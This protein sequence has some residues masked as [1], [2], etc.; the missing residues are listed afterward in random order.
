MVF[1]GQFIDHDLTLDLTSRFD[2]INEPGAITNFR[3]PTLDLD[4]IY[5]DGPEGSPFLYFA[6]PSQDAKSV[7]NGAKL[8]TGADLQGATPE[9]ADD[10][11]RNSNGIAVI[12]D[13]RNDENRVVSQ[14]QLA[15]IRVHN[16]VVEHLC[17]DELSGAHLFEEARRLTTWLYQW[18]VLHDFLT[19]MVGAPVVSDILGNGR[20]IYA[21][22]G[23][24]QTLDPFIP[25][26][27][28]VAAYRFG[29][30]MI[31]QQ[32]RIRAGED[33]VEVFS[34]E[35]GQGFSPV[36]SLNAVVQWQQ[37]LDLSDPSVD[38]A[39]KL[40]LEL[41]ADLLSLPFVNGTAAEKS[42][43]TRNMMRGQAFRL[44]SGETVARACCRPDSEIDAVVTQVSACTAGLAAD[45]S[46]GIPLWLYLLAEAQVVGKESTP[47]VFESGEG[48]GP[49]G[50]R[51]VGETLIGILELDPESF[52]GRDRS[53]SPSSEGMEIST[54][55]DL[56]TF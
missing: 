28:S 55:L 54:L 13:P 2:R 7:F 42:L 40:D 18:V 4:C 53:W 45:L 33:R 19:T 20:R 15:M 43:A 56:L 29:H 31:P 21:P 49:V 23:R 37:V 38:R 16:R 32:V 34:A 25:V 17:S 52:F 24:Q 11:L 35:L 22:T 27:F 44:P 8:L 46:S 50:A 5:G 14:L 41:A 1:F 39:D 51:I 9:Q 30:S 26:E 36:P 48:L 12:G 3:T 6:F 47:G 10:L